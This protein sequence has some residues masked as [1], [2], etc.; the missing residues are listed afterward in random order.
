MISYILFRCLSQKTIEKYAYIYVAMFVWLFFAPL[1]IASY[2][3]PSRNAI[4]EKFQVFRQFVY[5]TSVTM[6]FIATA[7]VHHP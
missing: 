4:L 5:A 2:Y 7:I 3:F 1:F 6:I